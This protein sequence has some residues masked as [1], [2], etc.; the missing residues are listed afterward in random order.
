MV[1]SQNLPDFRV[2]NTRFGKFF[3]GRSRSVIENGK[4]IV[5][6]HLMGQC[7][8]IEFDNFI[9]KINKPEFGIHNHTVPE[10]PIVIKR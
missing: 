10:L 8:T 1:V 7:V 4:K 5:F 2:F 6:V 3:C 9:F